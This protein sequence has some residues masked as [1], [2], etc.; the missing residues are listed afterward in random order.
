MTPAI[1]PNPFTFLNAAHNFNLG[2]NRLLLAQVHA[3]FGFTNWTA[4]VAESAYRTLMEQQQPQ[5]AVNAW[6]V[7][8]G[9]SSASVAEQ[10]TS[11]A[12]SPDAS[13]TG[14]SASNASTKASVYDN[15]VVD[16]DDFEIDIYEDNDDGNHPSTVAANENSNQLDASNGNERD[17]CTSAV[18]D[19]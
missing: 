1:V 13:V 2:P 19:D 4:L 5:P 3:N 17:G 7:G 12:S 10:R 8:G 18:Y 11:S 6:H 16:D 14:T 15:A 9:W